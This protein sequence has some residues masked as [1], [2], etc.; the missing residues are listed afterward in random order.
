MPP[1]LCKQ[2]PAAPP[3]IP[4]AP[5][6][7]QHE[8]HVPHRPGNVYGDDQHPVEQVKEIERKSR[9]HDIIKEPG[10]SHRP[11]LQMPG[12]LPGTPV[13]PPAHTPTPPTTSDSEDD[14]EWL[15]HEGGADLVAFLMSKAIPIKAV[16]AETKPIH[17]WTYR[18]ILKLPAAAQEE[19]KAACQRELDILRKHKVYKLVDPSKGH[20]VIDN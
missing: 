14:I 2:R 12:N 20:K 16:S 10:P 3:A 7:P 6:H 9:W 18:E 1:A 5:A 4:P 17:K 15:C 8:R 13:A 19:W 11:E